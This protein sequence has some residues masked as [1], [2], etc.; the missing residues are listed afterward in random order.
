MET[1]LTARDGN[2]GKYP[3]A[4]ALVQIGIPAA[5]E[6]IQQLKF[7]RF[8]SSTDV[9]IAAHVLERILGHQESTRR[10]ELASAQASPKNRAQLEKALEILRKMPISEK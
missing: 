8:E 9:T 6:I 1:E 2:L 10:L 5:S 4:L 7:D 3:C